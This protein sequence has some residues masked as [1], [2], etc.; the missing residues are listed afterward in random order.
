MST[1]RIV[2]ERPIAESFATKLAKKSAGLMVGDPLQPD[3]QIGAMINPSAMNRI[4]S[5]I[6][7]ATAKGARVLCGAKRLGPC[8]APTVLLGV[9]PEMRIYGEES[10][11][12][13]VSVVIAENSEDAL[14]IANDTEYGLSSAI[15]S[16]DINKAMKLAERLETGMCHINGATVHDEP[17]MR[18]G[19]RKSQAVGGAS[20]AARRSRNSPN[21]AG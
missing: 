7:D 4:E 3:T 12:P 2:I 18:F 11:G 13:V 20:A 19:R 8:Y 14:R 16:R 1:E 15:F 5:L 21:C 9:T 10:F 6:A 17:Q